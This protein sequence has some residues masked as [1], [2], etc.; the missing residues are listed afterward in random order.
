MGKS[1]HQSLA[2]K[3]LI[4]VPDLHDPNFFRTVVVLFQHSDEGA[5]GVVLN[6]PTT[7]PLKKIW[8]DLGEGVV[9]ETSE[10]VFVG[11]PV[12]GPLIAI[13]TSP[14]LA[15]T[16]VI[17]GVYLSMSRPQL[18]SLVG[19]KDQQFRIFSGYSGWGPGQLESEIERGGWLVLPATF[20]NIFDSPDGLWKQVCD[21]FGSEIL[22]PIMGQ[23]EYPD[24]PSLN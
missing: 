20:D 5:S 23:R 19:Q 2:G 14:P 12:E 8:E 7:I 15:E 9:C 18:D 1:N 24:D 11:G 10:N 6:Q 16:E 13:H 22:K 17:P 21:Q 3:L 4:A